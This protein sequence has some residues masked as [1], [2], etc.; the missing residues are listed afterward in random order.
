MEDKFEKRK[1]CLYCEKE[2][3]AKKR[4]KRFCSDKCRVYFKREKDRG[5]IDLPKIGHTII[6]AGVPY[7]KA[8]VIKR[9]QHNHA[10]TLTVRPNTGITK[11]P[12]ESG[13]D[14][15]IRKAEWEKNNLKK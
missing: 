7:G 8:E 2:M 1:V 4:S 3:E 11:N 10:L 13:I 12:G 9:K 14:F 15:A 6:V 5:T